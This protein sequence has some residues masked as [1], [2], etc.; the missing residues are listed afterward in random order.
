MLPLFP[1]EFEISDDGKEMAVRF[2][3][4]GPPVLQTRFMRDPDDKAAP[5]REWIEFFR[6]S[7][8]WFDRRGMEEEKRLALE[9][10]GMLIS[11]NNLDREQVDIL[12]R[13]YELCR[14]QQ[15]A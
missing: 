2:R 13:A 8:H 11:Y 14:K 9:A 3:V 10:A 12:L 15:G 5:V 7:H 6:R 4:G 1:R